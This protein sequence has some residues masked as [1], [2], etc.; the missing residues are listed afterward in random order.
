METRLAS[1]TERDQ[2]LRGSEHIVAGLEQRAAGTTADL[3][4]RLGD[5]DAQRQTIERRTAEANEDLAQRLSTLDVK[6]QAIDRA[7]IDTNRIADVLSG[8]ETRMAGLAQ[9]HELLDRIGDDVAHLERRVDAVVA[10]LELAARTRSQLEHEFGHPQTQL[11]RVTEAAPT[12][13][14]WLVAQAQ[15]VLRSLSWRGALV[16]GFGAAVLF[17][18]VATRSAYRSGQ[19]EGALLSSRVLR[20]PML[21]PSTRR[22]PQ[23][24]A[25]D[26]RRS[27]STARGYRGCHGATRFPE[28]WGRRLKGDNQQ[29]FA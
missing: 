18:V 5:F 13:I 2:L 20:L 10:R 17:G 15:E 25:R 9:K 26:L 4:R 23:S 29:S 22:L 12:A 3:E 24:V 27:E 7:S 21:V 28:K 11:E 8:L 1:L 6:Q 14:Q 19:N 16:A